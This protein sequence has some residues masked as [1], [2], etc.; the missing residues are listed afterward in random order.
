MLCLIFGSLIVFTP[1]K[2]T[3]LIFALVAVCTCVA[4]FTN[5][6]LTDHSVCDSPLLLHKSVYLPIISIG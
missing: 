2:E 1:S 5:L 6:I 3:E 4:K